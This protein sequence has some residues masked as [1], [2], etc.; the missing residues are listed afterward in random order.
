MFV[1]GAQG[2]WQVYDI[3]PRA[4]VSVVAVDAI[5]IGTD[6]KKLV[7]A[8]AQDTD[9]TT[10]TIFHM[11]VDLP[12]LSASASGEVNGFNIN[13]NYHCFLY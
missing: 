13:G 9:S 7:I 5:I 3:T 8:A 6:A 12:K 4:G 1:N 10:S 2:R 11:I